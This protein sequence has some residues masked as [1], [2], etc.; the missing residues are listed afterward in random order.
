MANDV[1]NEM[2]NED[3][4]NDEVATPSCPVMMMFQTQV[5]HR[6]SVV[7]GP[8]FLKILYFFFRELIL[9]FPFLCEA[10]ENSVFCAHTL[11]LVK[12]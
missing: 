9:P 3:V 5:Y 12:H 1:V 2:V 6:C 10:S 4:V 11:I 7:L 8:F